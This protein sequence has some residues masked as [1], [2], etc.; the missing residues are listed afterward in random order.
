MKLWQIAAVT[1]AGLLYGFFEPGQLT[2]AF[3]SLTLYVL[4][5]ALLFEGAWN[6]DYR[7]MRRQ[8]PAIITLAVPGVAL[9]ALIIAGAVSVAG[10]SFGAALLTGAILS[11][12]DPIA[13][14]A[15]FRRMP[16]PRMLRTLVECESLFND[17][18]A[19]V[20]YRAVLVVVMTANADARDVGFAALFA[21]AGSVAGIAFGTGIAFLA[22]T[23]LRSR[24]N[25]ILQIVTTLVCAYGTYFASE[26]LRISGI[27]AIISFGIA[28]RYFERRW[29]TVQLAEDV[30]GFWDVIARA[31]NVVVFFLIGA[32]LDVA[33]IGGG[34]AFVIAALIGVAVARAAIS[35]LL[36]P[37]RFPRSWLAVVRVAGL[38]GALSLALAIALPP[39]T[40]YREPIV[41]ATFAVA[42]ATI[43]T[44]AFT[45]PP[46][47][48]RV[49]RRQYSER[50]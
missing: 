50:K 22:A 12:T 1:V 43:I 2:D 3:G 11:A 9:T 24:K 32:A 29:V 38:R 16:V 27:F 42:I 44:S 21:V 18:I 5:P 14:V 25:A 33:R 31:A 36:L 15:A 45:I 19:V 26:R 4:L 35:A 28:L 10:A 6:L 48:A 13:V 7:A 17:A 46:V 47:V 30:E 41:V 8:G 34:V 49:A 40:P 23:V 37:G 20:L 39:H